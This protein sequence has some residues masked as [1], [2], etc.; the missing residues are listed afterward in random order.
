MLR[1]FTAAAAQLGPIARDEPRAS[2]VARMIALLEQAAQ[3]GCRYMVFPEL[4]LT[5]FFPRWHMTDAAEVQSY[6]EP[7]M[8][9]P[10][11]QPLF[12][13]ARRHGIG[14][15][16]GYA[17]RA[18]GREGASHLGYNSSILVSPTG[19]IIGKYRKVH[20]PG[21]ATPDDSLKLQHLE[22]WY[23]LD[24]DLGFPAFDIGAGRFGMLLCNDRRW[25]ESW[26][27][28]GLQGVELAMLGYNTP[29]LLPDSPAQNPLRKL[30]HLLPMQA[31]A[32]QNGLWIIAAA[33]AGL[34]EGCHMMGHS[35]IIAPSG[36][37]VALSTTDAD[38]L[39]PYRID[40]DV[41]A[42]YKRVF[43]FARYRRPEAYG[44]LTNRPDKA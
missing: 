3:A 24:G 17:E 21:N 40:L 9:G 20:L 29:S 36:E 35:C 5:T 42:E 26:R 19:E 41:T 10:D 12:D 15:Y 28:L 37:V 23:F 22:P 7:A 31:G 44:L 43:D 8:P 32:Y 2:V 27:M 11:T 34:E 16:L 6:F 4:A 25:P 14:F 1:Q 30:H 13:A 33:K 39:L 18:E 38:E